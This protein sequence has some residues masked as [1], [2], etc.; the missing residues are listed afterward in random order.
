MYLITA[1]SYL[2]PIVHYPETGRGGYSAPQARNFAFLFTTISKLINFSRGHSSGYSAK[3]R[4][5]DR[6][7]S[8]EEDK[9]TPAKRKSVYSNI[10]TRNLEEMSGSSPR[11][12]RRA[13]AGLFAG[14][15]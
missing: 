7:I 3:F 6:L 2:L 8:Y 5:N 13:R 12:I 4:M 9:N 14:L 1:T 15:T 11:A 10:K